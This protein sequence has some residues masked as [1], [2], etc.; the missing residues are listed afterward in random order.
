MCWTLQLLIFASFSFNKISGVPNFERYFNSGRIIGGYL[1]SIENV[2]WLAS[3]HTTPTGRSCGANIIH[4]RLLLTC[5]HCTYKKRT[6]SF[7]VL[8]GTTSFTD[9]G[10][11][12]D[13]KLKIQHPNYNPQNNDYDFCLLRIHGTFTFDHNVQPIE[14]PSQETSEIPPRCMVSGWGA[15]TPKGGQQTLLRSADIF[16]IDHKA[17]KNIYGA[18]IITKQMLCA[19]DIGI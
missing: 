15:I 1:N 2:P 13:I 6:A 5:A 14:L 12:F 8:V 9:D 4:E 19:G 11:R 10:Q 17:C 7:H 16:V 3:L 18:H